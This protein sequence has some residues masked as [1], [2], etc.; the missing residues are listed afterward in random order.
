M[1]ELARE[2]LTDTRLVEADMLDFDLDERFDV[3]ICMF[4]TIGYA[5]TR[6]D[7]AAV[8]VNIAGH[9]EEGGLAVIEPWLRK[10]D[11][12]PRYVGMHT[13]DGEDVKVARLGRLIIEED[14][15]IFE[16]HYLIGEEGE[17]RHVVD[18]HRLSLFGEDVIVDALEGA[19]LNAWFEGGGFTQDRGAIIALKP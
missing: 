13:S 16:A 1:L 3:I 19:G 4:S 11:I 17:I 9:L 7:M 10:E 12:R 14:V 15:S 6:E 8:A 2:K 5:T 18:R